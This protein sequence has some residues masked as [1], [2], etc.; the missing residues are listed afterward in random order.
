MFENTSLRRLAAGVGAI[1]LA[2]AGLL[3]AGSAH[4]DDAPPVALSPGNITQE[5]GNL[6]VHKHAGDPNSGTP[7]DG[8][9]ITPNPAAPLNGVTFTV[10]PVLR[11]GTAIDLTTAEGWDQASAAFTGNTPATLPTGYSLG[12]VAG[13]EVTDTVGGVDG[14]ALFDGL[15]LGLYVV[16]ETDPG[17]NPIVSPIAPFF[18]TVPY[19]SQTQWL[20]D[21]HVYP[22]NKLNETVPTKTVAD[23]GSAIVVGD[24]LVWTVTAPVPTLATGDTFDSFVISDDF[25]D[26][27]TIDTADV[28]VEI[29]GA[30][31]T[32]GTD[33]TITPAGGT[34]VAGPTVVI[35]LSAATRA[36]LPAKANVVV[37]YPTT[38]ASL[39]TT[40]FFENEAVVNAN[41]TSKTTDK[42]RVNFGSIEVIKVNAA[43][44]TQTLKGAE[45]ELYDAKEGTRVGTT[46]YVT[47]DDGKVRIDGVWVGVNPTTT[48]TYWLKETKAP[49]GYV[50][51]TDD[52][53]WTEVEVTASGLVAV[54]K[55][56]TN[57]KQTV[58]GLP[59]TGGVGTAVFG[60]TG[61]VLVLGAIAGGTALRRRQSAN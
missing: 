39:G 46:T 30:P 40:A 59:V 60:A 12:A 15:P 19:A 7:G 9:L 38:V 55:T 13:T 31:L 45:F 16:T 33:Y 24:E 5:T 3:G 29:D 54:T 47:G 52:E 48:K 43:A 6:Y 25:D 28:V 20:Y 23:P 49:V 56:I 1:A 58:P 10:Q 57:T 44:P 51:P 8:T 34:A 4:A 11:G 14:I 18:V 61:L 41:D 2:A 22:K 32:Q 36:T 17:T 26:R 50:A 37:T 21:V 27:L 35:T 53:A 42:P